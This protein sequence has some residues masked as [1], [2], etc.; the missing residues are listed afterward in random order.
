[1][2]PK[3]VNEVIDKDGHTVKKYGSKKY[4]DAMS[5][6]DARIIKDYM[7]SLVD[8]QLGGKWSY[9]RG[10]DTAGKTG[11]A[12]AF[13][14]GPQTA[15]NGTSVYN[16]TFVGYAPADNPEIAVTVVVPF[17]PNDKNTINKDVASAVFNAYFDMKK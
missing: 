4:G 13:Y 6:E 3:I 7:K 2:Q 12:E 14:Y 16:L 5:T 9:F 10:T 17:M 1:M 11:T 8:G 15:M